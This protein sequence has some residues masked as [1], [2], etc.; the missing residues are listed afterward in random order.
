MRR[1]LVAV[2]CI[3]G[4]IAPTATAATTLNVIPHGQVRAGRVLGRSSR[5][6]AGRYAGAD[7]RPPHAALPRRHRRAAHPERRRHR[8]LQVLGA[9]RPERPLAHHDRHRRGTGAGAGAVSARIKRDAYGV[10][11]IYTD[12]DAGVIFGAG[13]VIAE[14]RSL[15]LDQA[16]A[17]GVAALIDMPGVPGHPA[18]ARPLQL[19]ADQA[20]PRRG[21]PRSRRSRSRRRAPQGSSSS[22]TS[23]STSRASTPGTRENEPAD[24]AV[25][26]HRHLRAQRDQGAVPG[27]GRRPGGRQRRSAS[28]ALR[29][30]LGAKRGTRPTRTCAGATTRRR[31]HD[32]AKLPVPDQRQRR[33]AARHRALVNGSFTLRGADAARRERPRAGGHGRPSARPRQLA[34]NILIASGKRS[35][36]GLA[37]LRR[38]P[39]DRLQLPRPDAGDGPPRARHPRARRHVGAVPG[40]HAHRPRRGLRVDADLGRRRHHRHVR[41]DALRRL[42]DEVPVQGQVPGDG[43]RSTPAR[44]PRAARASSQVPPH[45]P[46]AGRGYA[47]ARGRAAVALSPQAL[48]L[49]QDTVDQLF[50][51]PLTYGTRAQSVKTSSTAASQTPQTFNS[52]YATSTVGVLHLRPAP[53]ARRRASTPTCRST[54]AGKYEWKG[55]LPERKHPQGI[56]PETGYIVNWNNKPAKDFPASDE[57]LGARGRSSASRLLTAELDRQP[58]STRWPTVLGAMNAAATEDVRG[59]SSSGRRSRRCSTG[60]GAERART[61]IVALLQTWHDAGGSRLDARPRRQDRRPRRGDHGRGVERPGERRAVRPPRQRAVQ[62]ARGR[63]ARFD[64]PRAAST[65]A[66]TSTWGRTSGRCSARRSSGAYSPRYC[67][68][69]SVKTCASRAVGGA[70]RGRRQARRPAGRRS[71]RVAQPEAPEAI[72]FAP[73]PLITMHYTNQPTGIHQVIT[74]TGHRRQRR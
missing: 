72:T 6:A 52:F 70:R 38:R 71:G 25:H 3:L 73:L 32:D 41:R 67:G 51:Q 36:D 11:H 44:S 60:Q 16:R 22:T 2:A 64:R 69:G 17:N 35:H 18:R 34:S 48:E 56:N 54:A 39:A 31:D 21:R 10:P 45:G 20:G 61:K 62:P 28:T 37:A 74:F 8:L 15:L 27:P 66:G 68:D 46:R 5:H 7:V 12:T 9:P 4:V 24:G 19:Q 23:T 65:A 47:K 49:R 58:R 53:D 57:P 63:S 13:Y 43:V 33:E 29:H 30:K 55:F 26:A 40:L 1:A 59:A 42:E 50:F 14:D